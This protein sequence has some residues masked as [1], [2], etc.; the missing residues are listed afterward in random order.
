MVAS[1]LALAQ[2]IADGIKGAG[3]SISA[4]AAAPDL[5]IDRGGAVASFRPTASKRFTAAIAKSK[6]ALKFVRSARR[7]KAGKLLFR[8]GVIPQAAYDSKVHGMPPSSHV[9]N[10]SCQGPPAPRRLLL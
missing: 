1:N 10:A 4:A 6:K 9:A 7:Y 3:F 2:D 5:G 8:T